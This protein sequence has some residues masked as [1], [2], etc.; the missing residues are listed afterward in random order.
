MS[1]D[2]CELL[3]AMY[4][5]QP[6]DMPEEMRQAVLIRGLP[7]ELCKAPF[8][9]VVLD[10]AGLKGQVVDYRCQQGGDS[11]EA[12]VWL[13]CADLLDFAVWHFH[14]CCWTKDILVTASVV[15]TLPMPPSGADLSA[16]LAD[17][18]LEA[19][20]SPPEEW[21]VDCEGRYVLA[22]T[23][24]GSAISPLPPTMPTDVTQRLTTIWEEEKCS[25]LTAE[26]STDAGASGTSV[27]SEAE[28]C[29]EGD[30][31]SDRG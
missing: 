25:E 12:L 20:L 15:Q 14:G 8:L 13:S 27:A 18:V 5:S 19:L 1:A 28:D 6:S 3:D 7:N 23:V 26:V 11:G 2:H 30:E 21:V 10:Q 31:G 9:Q 16:A 4:G 29:H 22:E 17:K 24:F